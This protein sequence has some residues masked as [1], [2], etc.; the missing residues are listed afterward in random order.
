MLNLVVKKLRLYD[1]WIT[2]RR[3]LKVLKL[4]F[5]RLNSYRKPKLSTME[6]TNLTLPAGSQ[7]LKLVFL[8]IEFSLFLGDTK[9]D[10]RLVNFY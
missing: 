7:N 9:T 8:F 10:F 2:L 1:L 3:R 5:L 4:Q 6:H